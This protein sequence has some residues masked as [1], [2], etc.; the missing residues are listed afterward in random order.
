MAEGAM[1]QLTEEELFWTLTPESNSIAAIVKHLWGNMLSRWTNFL[2]EDGE[3][4]FRN[5]DAEFEPGDITTQTEL[6]A[7]WE[8]GWKCTMDTMNT[9]K[10]E[11]AEK[12]IKIRGE[13]HTV[14]QAIQ[15]QL[16][17]YS[18][19]IGQIV[20]IAKM[21]KDKDWKTL[22]IAKGQSKQFNQQMFGTKK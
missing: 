15:R 5:R 10:P 18:A 14:V 16:A 7:K 3:K 6:M 21:R 12:T 9:L 8:E 4:D 20:Y 19:H 1:N 13:D 17:H 11:D 22:S 2:T